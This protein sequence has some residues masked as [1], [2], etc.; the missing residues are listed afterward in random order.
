MGGI[1]IRPLT[2]VLRAYLRASIEKV[3]QGQRRTP[4]FINLFPQSAKFGK[5]I[6]RIR[7]LNEAGRT[8]MN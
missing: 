8:A 3:A 4:G 2:P 5:K 7:A 1:K 6:R